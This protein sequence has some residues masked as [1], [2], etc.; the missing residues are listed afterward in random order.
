M[1]FFPINTANALSSALS[2]HIP[3]SHN[4]FYLLF[5]LHLWLQYILI[6]QQTTMKLHLRVH[7]FQDKCENKLLM[8]T[9]P[10][11]NGVPCPLRDEI[12]PNLCHWRFNHSCLK[13]ICKYNQ[14]LWYV[15]EMVRYEDIMQ[16]EFQ[17]RQH[18][19]WFRMH[20]FHLLLLAH[21][22]THCTLSHLTLSHKSC[23]KSNNLILQNAQ[24]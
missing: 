21:T 12:L 3:T 8:E 11:L 1:M 19:I 4:T 13:L 17:Y 9:F 2:V 6:P 20:I 10:F 16:I 15:S 22:Q 14:C 23:D 7:L 5:Y 24:S 18:E